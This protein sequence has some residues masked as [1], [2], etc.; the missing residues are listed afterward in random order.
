MSQILPAL[1]AKHFAFSISDAIS[2][3]YLPLKSRFLAYYAQGTPFFDGKMAIW[4]CHRCSKFISCLD[5]FL[6]NF[7]IHPYLLK[8]HR[9]HDWCFTIPFALTPVRSRRSAHRTTVCI[10]N[11]PG[12]YSTSL[13]IVYVLNWRLKFQ[14]GTTSR[15]YFLDLQKLVPH[16]ATW[17]VISRQKQ[18]LQAS[19]MCIAVFYRYSVIKVT[20]K[21]MF[22]SNQPF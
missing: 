13:S 14:H 12:P 4:F 2:L 19:E 17:R 3:T 6:F 21:F 18:V 5:L 9:S 7:L 8:T 1:H 20:K 11:P 10:F 16:T 22:S 15:R